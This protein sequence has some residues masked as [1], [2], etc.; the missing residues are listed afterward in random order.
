MTRAFG[1]VLLMLA[2][3]GGGYWW[4]AGATVNRIAAESL[5]AANNKA[6]G[7]AINQARVDATEDKSAKGMVTNSTTFQKAIA[8][9]TAVKTDLTARIHSGAVRLSV[10]TRLSASCAAGAP[11]SG[12][13][14][15]DGEA[16]AEL[17]VAGSEFLTGLLNEADLVVHQLT[18]C[19]ADLD[20]DR[21]TVNQEQP[22]K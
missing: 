20:V 7:V 11:A 18:A 16:R 12:T 10:P 15:R 14:G 8:N 9:E 1:A 19:Q 2:L 5:A 3:V 4:G 22:S 13:G 6:I 21:T 17:S